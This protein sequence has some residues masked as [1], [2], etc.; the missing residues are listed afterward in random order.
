VIFQFEDKNVDIIE[1]YDIF[2]MVFQTILKRKEA[3]GISVSIS[4]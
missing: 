1:S 2:N 3:K 4:R